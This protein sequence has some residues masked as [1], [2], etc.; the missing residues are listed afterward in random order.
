M[1]LTFPPP[2]KKNSKIS[3][4]TSPEVRR[5]FRRKL[6]QLDSGNRWCLQLS[7]FAYSAKL[8]L[9]STPMDCKQRSS[10]ASQKAPTNIAILFLARVPLQNLVMKFFPWNFSS[11][12]VQSHGNL[13]LNCCWHFF[14][15]NVP[16]KQARKLREKLRP[17]PPLS[18][19]ETSPKTSLSRN[20]LLILFC[21]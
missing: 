15:L 1:L 21:C 12:A 18:K 2:C 5:Q 3:F 14:A 7:F 4:Q 20:P 10:T 16:T 19:T 13:A 17:E 11:F 6:R 9:R 8:R